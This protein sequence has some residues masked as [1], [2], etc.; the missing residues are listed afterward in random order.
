MRWVCRAHRWTT[1]GG[2]QS[3]VVELS[4]GGGD[5][6]GSGAEVLGGVCWGGPEGQEHATAPSLQP[7]PHRCRADA[8]GVWSKR[9]QGEGSLWRRARCRA[10]V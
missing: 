5:W 4:F 8:A 10:G 3:A 1:G 9:G 7:G 6:R 2:G